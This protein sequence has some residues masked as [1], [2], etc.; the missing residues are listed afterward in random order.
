MLGNISEEVQPF[1]KFSDV[2]MKSS[3]RSAFVF[4]KKEKEKKL[5]YQ[6]IV[7]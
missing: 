6:I 5:S 4:M 2:G 3:L 7:N 1:A